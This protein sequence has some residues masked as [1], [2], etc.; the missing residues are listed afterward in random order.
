MTPFE[1]ALDKLAESIK[2][3]RAAAPEDG[4]TLVQCLQQIS[5]VLFYLEGQRVIAH[6]KY[7]NIIQSKIMEGLAVNRAENLAHIEVPEMYQLRKI[8]DSGYVVCESIR[9]QL[10]W[11]KTGMKNS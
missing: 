1:S 8:I 11:I 3:Y 4:D 7:Q 6:N 10:A 2:D 5:P 9:S